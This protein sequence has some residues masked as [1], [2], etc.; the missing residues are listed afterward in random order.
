MTKATA[1]L[2]NYKRPENMAEVITSIR[3]QQPA[4]DIWLWNNNQQD[5]RVYDVDQQFNASSN[6]VCWPRWLIEI[7]RAHV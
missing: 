6:F 7:G 2:L 1:I 3:M 4:V 5:A